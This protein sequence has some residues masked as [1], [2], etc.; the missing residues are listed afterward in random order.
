MT[1]RDAPEASPG[2]LASAR[3]AAG[4]A[5]ALGCARLELAAVEVE[6]ERLR[7][8]RAALWAIAALFCIGLGLVFAAVLLVVLAWDGP[9]EAVLSALTLAFLG[10]GAGAALVTRRQLRDKPR[11]LDAT[12]AALRRDADTLGPVRR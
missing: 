2:L 11:L 7:L 5:L 4:A 10:A 8:S 1:A 3:S 12:L 9:R 6:E